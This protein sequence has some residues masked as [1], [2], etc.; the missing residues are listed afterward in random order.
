LVYTYKNLPLSEISIIYNCIGRKVSNSEIVKR[1]LGQIYR[2]QSHKQAVNEWREEDKK[3]ENADNYHNSDSKSLS[4]S[5]SIG[6]SASSVVD[7]LE[8]Q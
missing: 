6:E 4:D 8:N 1:F 5:A 7:M 3:A 2:Q